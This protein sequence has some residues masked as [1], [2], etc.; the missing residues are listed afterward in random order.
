MQIIIHWNLHRKDAI[1]QQRSLGKT[2]LTVSEIGLGAA[3]IGSIDL[4]DKQVEAVLNR[5]LD[6]G[7]TFIDTAAIAL[8][9]LDV[10]FLHGF[11][12]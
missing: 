11:D 4:P 8:P 9:G 3:Q 1:I 12:Q 10:Y 2:G 7:I 6:L 5:A